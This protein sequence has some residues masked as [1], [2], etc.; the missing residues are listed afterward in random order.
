MVLYLFYDYKMACP[1]AS[2]VKILIKICIIYKVKKRVYIY[3]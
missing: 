3:E 1:N 2:T